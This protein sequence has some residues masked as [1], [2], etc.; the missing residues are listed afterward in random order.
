MHN[1]LLAAIAAL[2]LGSGGCSLVRGGEDAS[3]VSA[4]AGSATIR[5]KEG[6]LDDASAQAQELCSAHGRTAR[7]ERVTAAGKGDGQIGYYECV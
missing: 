5:F 6:R 1:N 2:S 7:L 3:V 4:N